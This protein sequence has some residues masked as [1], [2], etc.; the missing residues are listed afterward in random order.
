LKKINISKITSKYQ[1][2]IPKKIRETL[3][4]HAGDTVAFQ[5][6]ETGMVILRKAKPLDMVYLQALNDTLAEWKS[7][8]DEE[9]YEH[10]Q[11]L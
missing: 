9:S 11:D 5:V 1:T 8:E 6:T 3:G 10:L 7:K 2:T 4:L